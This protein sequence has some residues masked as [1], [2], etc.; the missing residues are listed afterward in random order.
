MVTGIIFRIYFLFE[1]RMNRVDFFTGTFFLFSAA[2]LVSFVSSS[3]R[4]PITEEEAVALSVL[5]SSLFM[6]L[7]SILIVRRLHDRDMPGKYA[8]G[9]TIPGYNIYFLLQL[10]LLKG[11][12]GSNRY[13]ADTVVPRL[14]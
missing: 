4:V 12:D 10:L 6:F 7:W 8:L 5:F 1:G 2:S 9:M 14:R 3:V 13:G 11:T